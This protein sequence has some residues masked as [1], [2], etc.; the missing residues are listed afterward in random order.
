VTVP[1]RL[2]SIRLVLSLIYEIDNT[3]RWI[4][5]PFTWSMY[6]FMQ[7]YLSL[8]FYPH[9]SGMTLSSAFHRIHVLYHPTIL[10]Q[11]TKFCPADL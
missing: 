1:A 7:R 2:V 3:D 6:S 5:P 11:I 4:Y 8:W 10:R 9:T